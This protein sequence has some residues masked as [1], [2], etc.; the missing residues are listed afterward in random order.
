LV[1]DTQTALDPEDVQRLDRDKG[2]WL[3]RVRWVK[4]RSGARKLCPIEKAAKNHRSVD[5]ELREAISIASDWTQSWYSEVA[6]Q[7][8][9]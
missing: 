5:P 7:R 4:E 1:A 3:Q 2:K 9:R 8:A 6:A